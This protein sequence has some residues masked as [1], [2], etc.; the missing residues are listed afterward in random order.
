MLPRVTIALDSPGVNRTF[1]IP[2]DRWHY[3]RHVLR[4]QIGEQFIVMDGI[5]CRWLAR[6]EHNQGILIA[7][8]VEKRELD[9][10]IHLGIAMPK[11]TGMETI[12]KQTTEL[13]VTRI[14]PIIS[15]Y[16]LLRPSSNKLDRWRKIAQEAAEL[17]C[18][19][20]VPIVD[21]PVELSSFLG[22]NCGWIGVTHPAPSLLKLLLQQNL[23][24]I[25]LLTG[26]EGGW[27]EQ[28]LQTATDR[29]WQRMSLAPGVLA[30][31]TAPTVALAVVNAVIAL[32]KR[33]S[34]VP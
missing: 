18:R 22:Q 2:P 29:G 34:V 28:E 5:G 30:A 15:H 27:T 1:A 20:V 12:V 13:G 11:G 16:T 25:T 24:T 26:S 23:T 6:L 3:L 21:D 10:E 31:T 17:A 9:L 19:T 8:L 14:T 4:L 33:D 7:P 32:G